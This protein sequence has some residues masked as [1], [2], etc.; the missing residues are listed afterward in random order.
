[1]TAQPEPIV[2][3]IKMPQVQWGSIAV[4]IA[5]ALGQAALILVLL[6]FEL[7]GPQR[8]LT[9]PLSFSGDALVFLAQNKS[10]ADNGWWWWNPREGAPVGFDALAFPI[11]TNV[12]QIVVW[13]TTRVVRNPIA[14]TNVAWALMVALSGLGASWCLRRLGAS[15]PSA[16]VAGTLF[17]LTPYA[18][19]RNVGHFCLAIYLVPFACTLALQLTSGRLAALR[20]V[21][22]PLIIGW[23]L[24][25][26]NYVY[27]AFF[28]GFL[29]LVGTAVGAVRRRDA[30][31]LGVGAALLVALS[32]CSAIN[33]APSLLSWSRTGRPIVLVDKEPA[34]S[35]IFGLK[36]RQLVSPVFHHR[37]P[38][39]E[40]WVDKEQ[41]AKFPQE[42]E[43][44]STRLGFIGSVGF[45][46]LLAMLLLPNTPGRFQF[47]EVSID[48]GRLVLAS[49][50][51]ATTGGFG[52]LLSLL[53]SPEIRAYNRIS[54]FIVF[55]CLTA[56]A[57]AIDQL[58]RR[59]AA[60]NAI[61]AA[62]LL[63]G[64]VDQARAGWFMR[65]EYPNMLAEVPPLQT[66]VREIET[67]VGPHAS[68]FQLPIRVYLQEPEDSQL[69][70]YDH[71]K[72]YLVSQTLS[73]SYPALSNEQMLW[74]SAAAQ[75]PL[76]RLPGQL[77]VE[78][79]AA[80]VIDRQGY[81][82]RGAEA[83]AAIRLALH[84][85]EPIARTERYVA[86]DLRS[87]AGTASPKLPR[88]LVSVTPSMSRCAGHELVQLDAIGPTALEPGAVIH[89]QNRFGGIRV[90]GWAVD[91]ERR[92]LGEAVEVVVDRT[93]IR[94]VY[95]LNR[96]D[97]AE[98]FGENAYRQSGFVA[99]VP[100]NLFGKGAHTIAVRVVSADPACYY[101][102]PG[103]PFLVE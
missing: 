5:G 83:E 70:P 98:H 94:A 53:V 8:D 15:K 100:S 42:N 89:A 45:L 19:Y 101:Q 54:P 65:H 21:H 46:G 103:T 63:V 31:V 36:I 87:V 14:A 75:V 28:A 91:G 72:P 9:M 49:L 77:A 22:R 86:Y 7:G 81:A 48:A 32:V 62:V 27:Y 88:S 43:N 73:W 82:D 67:R 66:F 61:A 10:T 74:Q 84:G 56:V 40:W 13:L 25:A 4:G 12:D 26:F 35:E 69:K 99:M 80:V 102:D 50:L 44:G 85:V 71:F 6:S 59:T 76:A 97:V 55:F 51:L 17:A 78:G 11:N 38:P 47:P 20:S 92:S 23:V 95:G 58:G 24:L 1:M 2:T 79:F 68:V 90:R 60:R 29:V 57:F 41:D 64:L 93:P 3:E 18:I 16:M 96:F 33:A 30:R 39:F 34:Q 37:F 52:S